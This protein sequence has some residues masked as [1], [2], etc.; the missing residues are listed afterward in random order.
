MFDIFIN[1][2][3]EIGN[4]NCVNMRKENFCRNI[5]ELL[6]CRKCV[7]VCKHSLL[8]SIVDVK[9]EITDSQYMYSYNI[10]E[11]CKE[12]LFKEELISMCNCA[13]KLYMSLVLSLP[14]LLIF[15][16][17]DPS[18]MVLPAKLQMQTF[19]LGQN[20]VILLIVQFKISTY[21]DWI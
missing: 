11:H 20:I 3:L 2:L 15:R 21:W 17:R 12:Q 7:C 14:T 6:T 19:H 16:V 5:V 4:V 9:N 18:S 1:Y 10:K 8:S 13:S